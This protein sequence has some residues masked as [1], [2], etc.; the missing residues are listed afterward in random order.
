MGL[1]KSLFKALW[2]TFLDFMNAQVSL[3][4]SPRV[5]GRSSHVISIERTLTMKM[6]ETQNSEPLGPVH[7]DTI[8]LCL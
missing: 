7:T 2:I 1:Y 8:A 5:P 6:T 3:P 4:C